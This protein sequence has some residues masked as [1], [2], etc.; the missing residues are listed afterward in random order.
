MDFDSFLGGTTRRGDEY[1]KLNV[2][3]YNVQ[4][5]RSP[6]GCSTSMLCVGRLVHHGSTECLLF[7]IYQ[8]EVIKIQDSSQ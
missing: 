6:S 3:T 5:L 8:D 1:W 4:G 2:M 7:A